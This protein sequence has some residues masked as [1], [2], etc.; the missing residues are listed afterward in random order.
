MKSCQ[1]NLKQVSLALMQYTQDY[2]ETYPLAKTYSRSP[3]GW[4]DAIYP[5][6]RSYQL[7]QCPSD[8]DERRDNPNLSGYTDYIFNADF[9]SL[10]LMKVTEPWNWVAIAEGSSADTESDAG[11]SQP[12]GW[13]GLILQVEP[14]HLE[15]ANYAFVDG[16]VKWFSRE[17][18]GQISNLTIEEAYED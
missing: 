9:S 12:M 18:M 1:S 4:S 10:E 13:Q 2:D 16:H 6:L 7:F 17:K 3:V 5:Y 11:Y 14:R 8:N 15:G